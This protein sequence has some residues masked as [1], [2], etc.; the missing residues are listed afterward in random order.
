MHFFTFI[1][2][3]SFIRK[4]IALLLIAVMLSSCSSR[5][6]TIQIK[7][8]QSVH[9]PITM[10]IY[11]K[12]ETTVE[13]I[14]RL[15][16]TLRLGYDNVPA[17]VTFSS[18]LHNFSDVY[19]DKRYTGSHSSKFWNRGGNTLITL[20]VIAAA[21]GGLGYIDTR[22]E[23]EKA[24]NDEKKQ[25]LPSSVNRTLLY[26]GG[27][28]TI[29]G[30]IFRGIGS[31]RSNATL[32]EM[33]Q[34][35]YVTQITDNLERFDVFAKNYVTS[36]LDKWRMKNEYESSEVYAR[37]VNASSI[38]EKQE[39][40]LD[41]AVEE[42]IRRQSPQDKITY[43]INPYDADNQTFLVTSNYGN[44][45]VP[46]AAAFAKEFK[47]NFHSGVKKTPAFG[48]N[49]KD[50]VVTECNFI[51]PSGRMFSANT[52]NA[53][54]Y[55]EFLQNP[56]QKG[57]KVDLNLNQVTSYAN[58][59]SIGKASYQAVGNDRVDSDIPSGK[60]N[61]DL[62]VVII[63]NENYDPDTKVKDVPFAHN[64][65]NIFRQYCEKTLGV[66]SDHIKFF[67]DAT[68]NKMNS[69]VSWLGNFV[70]AANNAGRESKVIY[71]Y[72]GHGVPDMV[73]NKSYLLPIDGY[74]DD[75]ST[76]V[77]LDDLYSS[78]AS[79]GA[80]E[81][82]VFLDACFSGVETTDNSRAVGQHVAP[83]E[84]P[85]SGN[86]VVI[87]A[88]SDKQTSNPFTDK[89]HGIFTYY[90]LKKLNEGKGRDSLGEIFDYLSRNV[91]HTS[92]EKWSKPQTP[93]V[94]P[95]PGLEG[96][97]DMRLVK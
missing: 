44:L 89:S 42:F 64:D 34:K 41:E 92:M 76:A 35:N 21:A 83:Q 70:K 45:V 85:V 57:V 52:N 16:V 84:K 11:G 88:A 18:E 91:N 75:F 79:L 29:L 10:T 8:S 82:V 39:M 61:E 58:R 2:K 78:L 1:E 48:V 66:S 22:K 7:G 81:C 40:L 73:N 36:R 24:E 46:V 54:A 31:A 56:A 20:G 43:S 26:G 27:G 15:P 14:S 71:Y 65:A 51:T 25:L 50:I 95:S 9:E 63:G 47:D 72:A 74:P 86:L 60:S 77:K 6:G 97:R 32:Y 67:T 96:W 68:R 17:R 69:A 87:S 93:T 90:L 62:Y 4:S 94:N 23:A 53:V 19:I 13:K 30:I 28:A 12:K 33:E 55:N 80:A 49:E 38:K 37:R 59:N 5:V 3:N